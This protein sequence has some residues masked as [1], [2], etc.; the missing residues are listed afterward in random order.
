MVD[1]IAV[2]KI[3]TLKTP[4][5]PSTI[6]I[7]S[8]K[9]E[10]GEVILSGEDVED[11][12]F[13]AKIQAAK[14]TKN[15]ADDA[16]ESAQFQFDVLDSSLPGFGDALHRQIR[17][18]KAKQDLEKAQIAARNAAMDLRDL[19]AQEKKAGEEGYKLVRSQSW[20]FKSIKKTPVSSKTK[21]SYT[22][23]IATAKQTQETIETT[24]G[25]EFGT[26]TTDSVSASVEIGFAY[27][28]VSGGMSSTVEHQEEVSE[29]ISRGLRMEKIIGE[30]VT[31]KVIK[32]E[33]KEVDGG[34]TGVVCV[35]W[36]LV[37]RFRLT[38]IKDNRT[39]VSMDIRTLQYP[40][41]YKL[42]NPD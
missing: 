6:P 39:V 38:R 40:M 35:I 7:E 33:E 42:S 27:K 1:T 10:V 17:K 41:Q 15:A 32:T 3:P 36:Q 24:T 13:A 30:T 11:P 31:N 23:E 25:Y 9:V 34:T 2:A 22:Q 29:Q 4:D 28:A 5:D 12:Q 26:K 16:V 21:I 37:D 14:A 18:V 19:I 8:D 20:R